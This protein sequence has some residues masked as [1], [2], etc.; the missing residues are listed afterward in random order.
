MKILSI[1]CIV[2]CLATITY[3]IYIYW[4]SRSYKFSEDEEETVRY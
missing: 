2:L 4:E 1:C 3:M